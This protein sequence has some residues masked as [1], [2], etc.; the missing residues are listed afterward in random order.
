MKYKVIE[1]PKGGLRYFRDGKLVSKTTIPANVF[2]QLKP[3]E[4]FDDEGIVPEAPVKTC[5]FCDAPTKI[6][7][8]VNLQTVY[9]CEEHYYDKTIGQIAQHLNKETQRA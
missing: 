3:D 7:R 4:E 2:A 8:L 5:I 1:L 9:I 6:S